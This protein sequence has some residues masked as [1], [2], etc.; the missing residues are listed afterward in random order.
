LGTTRY[1]NNLAPIYRW[2][3]RGIIAVIRPNKSYK[4]H[5]LAFIEAA[6]FKICDVNDWN[7][8]DFGFVNDAEIV[9][10]FFNDMSLKA[11]TAIIFLGV[12]D[13]NKFPKT[14]DEIFTKQEREQAI[15]AALISLIVI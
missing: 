5:L 11:V 6:G 13:T 12:P 10:C 8:V 3:K 9:E 2:P 4:S 14:V 7:Q 1:L 15:L